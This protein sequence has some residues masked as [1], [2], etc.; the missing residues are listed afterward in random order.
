MT[1]RVFM[2]P[3]EPTSTLSAKPSG[4]TR[5]FR[6]MQDAL[7][8]ARS[9]GRDMRAVL[10]IDEHTPAKVTVRSREDAARTTP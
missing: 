10:T 9:L 2:A 5:Q 8:W 4:E 6:R 7:E 1:Y 3:A